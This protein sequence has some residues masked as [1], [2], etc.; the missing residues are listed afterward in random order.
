VQLFGE[1]DCDFCVHLTQTLSLSKMAEKALTEGEGNTALQKR[2]AEL[3]ER[4]TQL[5]A[6]NAEMCLTIDRSNEFVTA[7]R[8]E[9]D[10]GIEDYELL[11]ASNAR[12]LNE[13]NEAQGLVTNLE[14]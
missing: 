9:L 12:L 4:K 1:Y 2:I 5:E 13:C 3:E 6:S 10:A 14:T 7:R 8:H 11:R